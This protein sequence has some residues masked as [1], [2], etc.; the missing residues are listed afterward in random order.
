MI[1]FVVLGNITYPEILDDKYTPEL[2]LFITFFLLDDKYTP[3]LL[4]F[5]TFFF[6]YKR[7][8]KSNNKTNGFSLINP[9]IYP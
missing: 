8:I 2:L 7:H 5:I 9:Y 1:M 4:L 3:E 6:W